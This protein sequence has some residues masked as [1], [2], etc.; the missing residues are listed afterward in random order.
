M[1]QGGM[2]G[3]LVLGRRP[4]GRGQEMLLNTHDAQDM[5]PS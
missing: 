3:A 2:W 1:V 5:K 4:V